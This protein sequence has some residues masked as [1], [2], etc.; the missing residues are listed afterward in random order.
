MILFFDQHNGVGKSNEKNCWLAKTSFNYLIYN[1][2][3][4]VRISHNGGK[5]IVTKKGGCAGDGIT[6]MHEDVS[7][8]FVKL[9]APELAFF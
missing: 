2:L 6:W 5:L 9:F 3:V 4:D 7:V 1:S 8:E